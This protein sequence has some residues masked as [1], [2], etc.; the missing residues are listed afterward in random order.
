VD[1]GFTSDTPSQIIKVIQDRM[2]HLKRIY[3]FR[4]ASLGFRPG[5]GDK[6]L[7]KLTGDGRK[8]IGTIRILTCNRVGTALEYPRFSL[9]KIVA[10]IATKV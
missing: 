2:G 1:D 3:E 8:A 9:A 6:L 10:K 7:S 5:R 4:M